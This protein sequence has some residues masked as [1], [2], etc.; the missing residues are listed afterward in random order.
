LLIDFG[1]EERAR[2]EHV[3]GTQ[4][5]KGPEAPHTTAPAMAAA[6]Q[7]TDQPKPESTIEMVWIGEV[8]LESVA[9][10]A[11]RPAGPEA[12]KKRFHLM[13]EGEPV[14]V[15]NAKQGNAV[16]RKLEYHTETKQ[17]WLTGSAKHPVV[18][19][20]GSDRQIVVEQQLFF[21]YSAGI[22]R[23][24]GPGRMSRH[25][26]SATEE[27]KTHR[28]ASADSAS[29]L[30]ETASDVRIAWQRSGQIE[31]GRVK[32]QS[33]DATVEKRI[34][35]QVN[36]LKHAAF[37]GRV[38][39]DLSD[40]TVT[41]DHVDVTFMPPRWK[42]DVASEKED[43]SA[44]LMGQAA[45]ERVTATGHVRMTLRAD[46]GGTKHWQRKT[47]D[48]T[49]HRLEIEMVLDDT[50]ENVP[51][52][53]R[54]LGHVVARQ[55]TQPYLGPVPTGAPQVR[56][57]RTEDEL[58][59]EMTSVP[60]PATQE[61]RQ[62]WET[63]ARKQGY[64]PGSPE[65]QE[66]QE[67][68][69]AKYNKR[70]E[71]IVTKMIAQGN[72]TARDEKQELKDLHGES[73]ECTF[74]HDG[75]ISHAF[76]T[77]WPDRP[78]HVEHGMFYIRGRQ[79]SLDMITETIQVPGAG[80][81]RFLSDQDIDGGPVDEPIPVVVSWD[82]RMWLR[83]KEN[84][85]TFSNKVRVTSENNTLE[86]SRELRLRFTSVP[87][88]QPSSGAIGSSRA[89]GIFRSLADMLRPRKRKASSGR[90]GGRIRKR[91]TRVDTLG[92]AV[93]VSSAYEDL[94][95]EGFNPVAQAIRGLIPEFIKA[96]AS[97]P[98]GVAHR[99]L[100]SR[101]RLAGPQMRID[102]TE[103]QLLVEGS[104][105]LLIEDYRIPAKAD[106]RPEGRPSALLSVSS[107]PG[108]DGL[109]PSQT[110][111][112]WENSMTFL[113]KS[114]KAVFDHRVV[115]RH[116]AG[117]EMVL[118]GQLEAALKLD[119]AVKRRLKSRAASLTCNNL[120]AE[121]ERGRDT[122]QTGPSPLSQVTG[123]TGFWA[124]GNA[125]LVNRERTNQRSAW[126]SLISYDRTSGLARVI[127]TGR[128]PAVF[129]DVNP[130]TGAL[131]AQWKGEAFDWDLNTGKIKTRK[132][133]ILAPRR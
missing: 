5:A 99:R 32:L 34:T 7:D 19:G 88:Q 112:T 94:G 111:I 59:I 90:L 117:S 114:N 85:G 69:E 62:Q 29:W 8:R 2:L 84:I 130:Q 91:L 26:S 6:G 98:A 63:Y 10:P 119:E 13:A 93:I 124:R 132:S 76:I 118:S 30:S 89:Q 40:R 44:D 126:G 120:V 37:E 127:G 113:N 68:L 125:A 9:A 82:E 79:V 103:E 3:P 51:R 67:K 15:Q 128:H 70:R 71:V 18:L 12:P 17:F 81:L 24:E 101:I 50:G 109:G 108:I 11:T 97:Q 4:P 60:R 83:G 46:R 58:T 100:L 96:P 25:T 31:F 1:R 121:F 123:L 22:A 42:E 87:Q 80:L 106:R 53:A 48:V 64:T 78:A 52:R 122:R 105:N 92:D 35:K 74:D 28:L 115:M 102:L 47:E 104:G 116:R 86:A 27:D 49:C 16:C 133:R 73:L 77:G 129:Q 61:E 41:A 110:L 95:T 43:E 33:P 56:E 45:A 65:W 14:E 20:A 54:A 75:R 36:Y 72:V 57:I 55:I 131:N 38:T 107:V 66:A 23:I 39:A 21:D